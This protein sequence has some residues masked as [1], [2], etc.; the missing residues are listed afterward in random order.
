MI[1]F[2]ERGRERSAFHLPAITKDRTLHLLLWRN[3][4]NY[5]GF[6]Q[7]GAVALAAAGIAYR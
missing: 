6:K 4:M 2:H 5:I 3:T 1:C 7:V